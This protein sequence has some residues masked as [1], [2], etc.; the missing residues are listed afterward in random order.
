MQVAW[1]HGAFP[2]PLARASCGASPG[3]RCQAQ[4]ADLAPY[5]AGSEPLAGTP[6]SGARAQLSLELSASCDHAGVRLSVGQ[7]THVPWSCV[8]VPGSAPLVTRQREGR[9][10]RA[11]GSPHRGWRKA[12][13]RAKQGLEA[14]C[15]KLEPPPQWAQAERPGQWGWGSR[16]GRVGVSAGCGRAL[17]PHRPAH[18]VASALAE[19]NPEF[20]SIEFTESDSDGEVGSLQT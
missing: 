2:G 16:S 18:G 19:R 14:P 6:R 5:Q 15:P 7:D 11:P 4:A 10:L 9:P 20:M 12:D 3:F 13:G 8:H 17:H 1:A